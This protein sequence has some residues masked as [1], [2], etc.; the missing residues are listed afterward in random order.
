MRN[1]CES[2]LGKHQYNTIKPKAEEQL[3]DQY[4]ASCDGAGS[5]LVTLSGGRLSGKY[6][7]TPDLNTELL[8]TAVKKMMSCMLLSFSP[9]LLAMIKVTIHPALHKQ[10]SLKTNQSQG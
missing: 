7:E 2:H 8:R 3:G 4:E 1:V 10:I 5:H 9:S 6:T